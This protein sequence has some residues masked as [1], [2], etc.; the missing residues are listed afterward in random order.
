MKIG[1]VGDTR[2]FLGQIQLIYT[3][4]FYFFVTLFFLSLFAPFDLGAWDGRL[5][6]IMVI[7][8]VSLYF[9]RFPFNFIGHLVIDERN[10]RLSLDYK[11]KQYTKDDLFFL[12]V[13]ANDYRGKIKR[14]TLILVIL[15]GT[16]NFISFRVGDEIVDRRLFVKNRK[17]Y[18]LLKKIEK[19]GMN[20]RLL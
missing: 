20:T 14:L 5:L 4:I 17:Q 7:V 15:P 18:K 9:I 6:V 19:N 12:R 3:Y 11:G 10:G 13:K 2:N 1:I 16:D 8:R